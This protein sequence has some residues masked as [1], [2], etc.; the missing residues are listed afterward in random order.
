MQ[1]NQLI[2]LVDDFL[3]PDFIRSIEVLFTNDSKLVWTFSP[4]T[5]E[6][7]YW[8]FDSE[9]IKNNFQFVHMFYSEQPKIDSGHAN[10]IMP[11]YQ[12]LSNC[13]KINIKRLIRVKANFCT[14][15][16]GN[17]ESNH[18]PPHKD[19]LVDDRNIFSVIFYVNDS[20][21]DTLF[22]DE[23]NE[24]VRRISPR[25]GRAVLFPSV[26]TH[27]GKNPIRHDT[28]IIINAVLEVGN[29]AKS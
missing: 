20:D 15:V 23:N 10:V 13:K 5:L 18:Q 24:I 22:F 21:G 17:N 9:K 3:P 25:R 12:H 14:N 1:Q 7:Q 4:S 19:C 2:E 11:L 27:A 28:R 26:L 6:K 16:T 8:A 29:D